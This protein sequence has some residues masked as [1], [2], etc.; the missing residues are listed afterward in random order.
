M[1]TFIL[2]LLFNNCPYNVSLNRSVTEGYHISVCSF[3]P[4]LLYLAR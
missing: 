3:T 4:V 2:G 1:G